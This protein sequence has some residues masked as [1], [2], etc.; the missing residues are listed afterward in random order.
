MPLVG[1]LSNGA[2]KHRARGRDDA[3]LP[4]DRERI[5]A[6]P[7]RSGDN[8]KSY[9]PPS[10]RW[11][12]QTRADSFK[13]V[14]WKTRGYGN[15]V[16]A[17]ISVAPTLEQPTGISTRRG[18]VAVVSSATSYL[19]QSC[20]TVHQANETKNIMDTSLPQPTNPVYSL[21]HGAV[22]GSRLWHLRPLTDKVRQGWR[23]L[24]PLQKQRVLGTQNRSSTLLT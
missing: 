3:I 15:H 13:M 22:Q 6:F 7:P 8:S 4:P 19:K 11:I 9:P 14:R 24:R 12:S 18:V 21:P 17:S 10:Y 20:G 5:Q 23:T 1:T 2:P 16:C